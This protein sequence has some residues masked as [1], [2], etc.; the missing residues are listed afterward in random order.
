M[1]NI[2]YK[3]DDID[4]KI[5]QILQDEPNLT[6][7]NIAR[8]IHRS[9]PTV[10]QR[11]KKLED[12]GVLTRHIGINPKY[13]DISCAKVEIKSKNSGN[14]IRIMRECPHIFQVFELSGSNNFEIMIISEN[15]KDLD[16]VVNYHFRNDPEI[17][18][19][20][21]EIILDTYDDLIIPIDLI[22][23]TCNC[24]S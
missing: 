13:I 2:E 7:T 21:L 11:I 5:V 23:N 8:K 16:K 18:V 1:Q 24:T 4:R 3:L 22:T 10:G 6:Y 12:R 19:V 20:K 14:I 9:Q 15:L 17:D